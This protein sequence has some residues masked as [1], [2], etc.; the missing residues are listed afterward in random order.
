MHRPTRRRRRLAAL[1]AAAA[2][3][4]LLTSLPGADAQTPTIGGFTSDN[5][6]YVTFVPF[7]VGTATGVTIQGKYMYLTSWK[8]ISIY[9]ISNPESPQLVGTPFPLGFKFEN[10]N[11]SV[12]PGGKFLLFSESLPGDALHIYDV[13]D[14]TNIQL[15]ATLQGAG[16]HTTTC[17]LKCKWAYGSDGTIVDLRDPANPVLAASRNDPEKNWHAQT[18]LQ[19][20]G[21]DVEEFKNGFL[22][23]SP[24][25]APLQLLDVRNPM[26][27]KVL[28]TGQNPNPSGFLFHSGR[29]PRKGK[30]RFLLMQGERNAQPRCSE[31]NG[32]FMTF[33][34]TQWKK[35]KTFTLIDTFRVQNGTFVDGSPPVNGLGCSAHWFEERPGF[36]NGGLVAIGYYEHGTRFLQVDGKGKITEVG[37]FLPYGGSTSAAYWVN[38]DIVYAI[39]YTRGIDVLRYNG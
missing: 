12:S 25:S 17:I 37:W 15:L 29:W 3:P 18:G 23:T 8:N 32:P 30:D 39:D 13:E 4:L 1:A 5:V 9:D 22:I 27:P 33:D 16:D 28:A 38:K 36:K 2:L 34:A 11:V 26:K 20:G 7:E 35:T 24:I 19:G 10:E 14:K 6:E 31:N 21:H